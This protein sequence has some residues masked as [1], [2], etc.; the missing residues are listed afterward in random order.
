[1]GFMGYTGYSLFKNPANQNNAT[2]N[3]VTDTPGRHTD[4]ITKD[5]LKNQ[6]LSRERKRI[7][8]S[9]TRA[10]INEEIQ[11]AKKNQHQPDTTIVD[12]SGT[13]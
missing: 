13:Q 11:K 10:S 3:P 4:S 8:D 2:L 12:T 7:A 6:A 1:V 9:I 5:R